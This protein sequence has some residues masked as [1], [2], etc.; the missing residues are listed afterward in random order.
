MVVLKLVERID[1]YLKFKNF[2][3]NI[4]DK[5]LTVEPADI[6]DGEL[7]VYAI[8]GEDFA[9]IESDAFDEL[10]PEI[11]EYLLKNGYA[12]L[13]NIIFKDEDNDELVA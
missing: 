1:N 10:C 12:E 6:F 3:S 2:N 9:C 4:P 5:Y 7:K 8:R 11:S 13:C